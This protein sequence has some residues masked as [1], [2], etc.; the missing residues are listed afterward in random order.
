MKTHFNLIKYYYLILLAIIVGQS[1]LTCLALGQ[2][3]G[4]H[5]RLQAY[6]TATK[7]A[8]V[9]YNQGLAKLSEKSSLTHN[10]ELLANGYM[11]ISEAIVVQS[12]Q[13]AS[14]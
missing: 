8:L 14:R 1:L 11:P 9:E 2:T 5:H 6:Q 7:Q 13:L 10:Y 3:I 12:P 4:C